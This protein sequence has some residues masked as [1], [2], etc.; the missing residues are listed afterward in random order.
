MNMIGS[1][2][3]GVQQPC[4]GERVL[5]VAPPRPQEALPGRRTVH[6]PSVA[7][8]PSPGWEYDADEK[9]NHPILSFVRSLESSAYP[10]P[11]SGA[12]KMGEKMKDGFA[13]WCVA[14]QVAPGAWSAPEPRQDPGA[15][16]WHL[17]VFLRFW[18]LSM[19]TSFKRLLE[20]WTGTWY[21]V[22][23]CLDW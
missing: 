17:K 7:A 19:P 6:F 20:N 11:L 12:W 1:S 2:Q 10:W 23:S 18:I 9:V 21:W 5:L 4:L 22:L 16:S 15:D 8:T 14:S 13:L 3:N